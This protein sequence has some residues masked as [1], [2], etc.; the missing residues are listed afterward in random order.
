MQRDL[1]I[2][3]VAALV[4]CLIISRSWG[5]SEAHTARGLHNFQSSDPNIKLLSERSPYMRA[6]R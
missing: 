4:I 2:F 1:L 6:E 5:S 3:G